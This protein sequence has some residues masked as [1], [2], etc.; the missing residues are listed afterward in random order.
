MSGSDPL[1]QPES[2]AFREAIQVVTEKCNFLVDQVARREISQDDFY[3]CLRETGI[4]PE[5]AK[6]YIEQM[7]QRVEQQGCCDC[8]PPI[9]HQTSAAP[10]HCQSTPD[11]A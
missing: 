6:D 8:R 10:T 9:S 4:T 7:I 3:V 5:A 11:K 2:E 1:T